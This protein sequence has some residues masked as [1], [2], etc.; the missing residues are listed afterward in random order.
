MGKDV[1]MKPK[2]NYKA[3]IDKPSEMDVCGTPPYAFAVLPIYIPLSCIIWNPGC[4]RDGLLAHAMRVA[5]YRVIE[6]DIVLGQN[7]FDYVPDQHWD[8]I[9]ENPPFGIK[10]AWTER[11]YEL[12]KPF[13]LLMPTEFQGNV[14]AGEIF[15]HYGVEIMDISPR[16]DFK[17]PKA[18]WFSSAQFPVS[19]YCHQVL[20]ESLMFASLHKPPRT[21]SR[22]VWKKDK[23][24]GKMKLVTEWGYADW[25]EH[26][27][28]YDWE[29]MMFMYK[30]L[31]DGSV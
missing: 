19:W 27:S 9:V 18:G 29:S 17:M 6:T 11:C 1:A 7:F 28:E 15:S 23:K 2:E 10:P 4:G 13:A 8:I 25:I 16:V 21:V 12:G 31:Q 22:K 5:G 30:E 3:E 26:P 14:Q 20:P 24:T